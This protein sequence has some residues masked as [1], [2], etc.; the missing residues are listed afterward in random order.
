MAACGGDSN[1]GSTNLT[2]AQAAVVGDAAAAQIGGLAAGLS[3][4]AAPAVGGLGSGFFAPMTP[5]GRV[6]ATN[7]GRL[8]PRVAYGLARL[9]AADCTPAQSDSTDT[10]GD[11]VQDDNIITFTAANCSFS[12]TTDQGEPVTF[13]VSGTI[14][15]QDTDGATTFFGYRVGIGALT[16]T[17]RDTAGNSIA[18]G[19][20]GA[21]D[22]SVQTG[23]ASSSQDLRNSLRVNGVKLYGD[24]ANWALTYTPTGGTIF[25]AAATLPPGDF[26]VNGSYNWS[27]QVGQA[28]G[29]WSFALQTPLPLAYDGSCADNDWP[30]ESGQLKGSITARRSVGFTVDYAGCGVIGTITAYGNTP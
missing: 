28:D 27:G 10:D 3:H 4:F 20:T 18:G 30:F 24:H 13:T 12:D 8:N 25:P 17:I 21:F 5:G 19:I 2:P 9:S 15:V 26:A 7:I 16:V 23:L 22:A 11:G 29:D 6:L 1:T 14:R